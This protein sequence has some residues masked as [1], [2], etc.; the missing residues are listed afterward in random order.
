ML[1]RMAASVSKPTSTAKNLDAPEPPG[2]DPPGAAVKAPFGGPIGGMAG[3]DLD[4]ALAAGALG[5]SEDLEKAGHRPGL[6][7]P[8]KGV[9]RLWRRGNAILE[10]GVACAGVTYEG[11]PRACG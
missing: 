6:A 5:T 4:S 7:I 3:A 1:K 8:A 10:M 11:R 2:P 9:E